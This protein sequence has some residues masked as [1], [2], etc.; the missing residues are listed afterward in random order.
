MT[1]RSLIPLALVWVSAVLSTAETTFNKCCPTGE[2]FSDEKGKACVPAPSSAMELYSIGDDT[3]F[4]NC[5]VVDDIRITL[6]SSMQATSYLRKP[7]LE[8][9]YQRA[10]RKS[11]PIVVDCRSNEDSPKEHTSG[12][13]SPRL[14]SVRRCCQKNTV[15]DV[16]TKSCV[17]LVDAIG[18]G[19]YSNVDEFISLLPEVSNA[20]DFFNVFKGPPDCGREAMFTYEVDTED[21]MFENGLIKVKLPSLDDKSNEWFNI[22]AE[23]SCVDLTKNSR[24]KRQLVVRVCRSS[25]AC[26]SH[27]CVKK[28]CP[29]NEGFTKTLT[30]CSKIAA[31]DSPSIFYQTVSRLTNETWNDT[32]TG[33]WSALKCEFGM[34][35]I[36]G[37][38]ILGLTPKGYLVW[39]KLSSIAFHDEY[40]LEVFHNETSLNE[41]THILAKICFPGPT[42]EP[43]ISDFRFKVNSI[44]EMISCFFLLLTLLV[45][46]CLPALQNLH[47]KTLMCHAASLLM[48][49]VCLAIM[50]WLT[51]TRTPHNT[52]GGS[53][54]CTILGIVMYFS[55]LSTFSWLNIMCFDI[56]RTFGRLRGNVGRGRSHDKKF[57]LYCLYSWGLALTI[58]LFA[59]LSDN[60]YFLPEYL[61]PNFGSLNCWFSS[62]GE[63]IFFRGPVAIQL[64]SNVVFFI[65][66]ADHCSKVKAEIRRVADPSD[67]RSKRFHAD[68][69]KLI[70]I[71]KLFVVMG[72]FWILEIVSS[73]M[74]TYTDFS[75]RHEAF[76]PSDVIN[77]LQGLLIFILFVMKPR[78]YQA[79]RNRCGFNDKKKKSNQGITVPQDPFKV[80]KSASSSTLTSSYAVSSTP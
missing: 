62:K 57:L 21:V 2:I 67:P 28:C 78:V 42:K 40:C 1:M 44:L 12:V 41:T 72:I 75:W 77:C 53:K 37:I 63:L 71:V 29:E 70:M 73:I 24:R 14:L 15:F 51:P 68:K 18:D 49:Y 7:C 56:W 58:T 30:N 4:P 26:Q 79:L 22:T 59:I 47:G 8:I 35:K 61:K 33:I 60:V 5:T 54:Y 65:L 27:S 80:K 9:L 34:Y 52:N 69:T 25:R 66:T 64:I 55:F 13:S 38:E 17:P 32:G 10:T 31:S 43:A 23:N 36:D 48:S 46:I 16:A 3:S 50:P 11:D 76:Y 19:N 45:Y 20:V 6:L 74:N 39:S